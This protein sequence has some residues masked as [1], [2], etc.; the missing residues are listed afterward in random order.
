[1]SQRTARPDSR[2]LG[3]R[4]LRRRAA[5]REAAY[6]GALLACAGAAYGVIVLLP[7]KLK[8]RRLQ[9]EH[10]R[11]AEQVDALRASIDALRRDTRALQ[12]DPWTVERTL[13]ARLG[14]LRPGEQVVQVDSGRSGA[15]PP[16]AP[17]PDRD[18]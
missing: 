2:R 14:F 8:T 18:G 17:A 15:S 3:V 9:A 12:D 5:L 16:P 11:R 10:T 7:S 1:M 4:R 6:L 13:R